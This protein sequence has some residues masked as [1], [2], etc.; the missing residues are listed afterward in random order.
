MAY[1]I[2]GRNDQVLFGMGEVDNPN[3]LDVTWFTDCTQAQ[4]TVPLFLDG[5]FYYVSTANGGTLV[6]NNTVQLNGF[7]YTACAG[8]IG[9]NTGTTL[10]ASG[11]SSVT[12]STNL[13]PGIPTPSSGTIT[14]Y[15]FESQTRISTTIHS[16]TVR[17]AYRLGFQESTSNTAPTRG[18]YYEF[19]CN[20]TITDSTWKVV[21]LSSSGSTRIDTGMTASTNTTYRMYLSTEASPD[22]TYTTN[23]KIKNLTNGYNVES[24]ASPSLTSHYPSASTSYL[25]SAIVNTKQTTNTATVTQLLIDYIGTRIRR[26]VS[27]EILIAP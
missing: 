18:V 22:G 1:G 21:I 25:A 5:G 11:Y 23:Y 7:G 19:L 3:Q 14:K 9:L 27:R 26:P 17:G 24:T 10:N 12:T 8:T 15:E 6:N 13:L 20:G 4:A 16:N 2:D